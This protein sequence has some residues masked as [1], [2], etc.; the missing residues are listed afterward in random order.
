MAY[1]NILPK[2]LALLLV[3]L[4]LGLYGAEPG[5]EKWKIINYWSEWCAPCRFEIPMLNELRKDLSSSNVI[6][7]GVNFDDDPRQATL[8][9]A[10]TMGIEFPVLTLEEVARLKLRAPDVLP[11]TY[12]LSPTNKVVAKLVGQQTHQDLVGQLVDLGLFPSTL[13]EPGH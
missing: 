13:Q 5:Q 8:E 9:I 10:E 3:T 11:T 12:I 6:V 4:P 1:S 7:L 2:L